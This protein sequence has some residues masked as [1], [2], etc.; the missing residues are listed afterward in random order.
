MD[1]LKQFTLDNLIIEFTF[2]LA[3]LPRDGKHLTLTLLQ[4][5]LEQLKAQGTINRETRIYATHIGHKGKMLHE[6]CN[7]ALK[8]IWDGNIQTAYDGLRI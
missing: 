1:Y 6:E 4:E 3:E 7:I 8:A 2:G 5:T